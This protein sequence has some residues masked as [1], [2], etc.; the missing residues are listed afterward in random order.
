M[1]GHHHGAPLTRSEE[2]QYFETPE[3][4]DILDP[5]GKLLEPGASVLSQGDYAGELGEVKDISDPQYN[6]E[7]E[8]VTPEILVQFPDHE[9]AVTFDT[10]HK[11]GGDR[12][13]G[14]GERD[15]FVCEELSVVSSG[16]GDR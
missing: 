13:T 1:T 9:G 4:I 8:L 6:E 7:G 16:G 10:S 12:E 15:W 5:N 2:E 3:P 14:D 11:G